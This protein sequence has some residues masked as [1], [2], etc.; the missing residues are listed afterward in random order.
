ALARV[1][2]SALERGVTLEKIATVGFF[3]VQSRKR[4]DELRNA[5]ARRVDLDGNR[6]RVAVVLDEVDD[7]QL[8][9]ARRVERF[10]K[11]ALA[12]GAVAGRAKHDFV[13]LIAVGNVECTGAED[14]FGRPDRLK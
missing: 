5:S 4:R 14:R 6:D 11:L 3:E 2:D 1:V 10:P 9:V 12:R 8:E 13:L 7:R